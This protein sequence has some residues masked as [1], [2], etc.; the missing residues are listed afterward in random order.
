MPPSKAFCLRGQASDTF[1][2][3]LCGGVRSTKSAGRVGDVRGARS[4]KF[5][6]CLPLDKCLEGRLELG[7]VENG[8]LGTD[9]GG[10][11]T[12]IFGLFKNGKK[13]EDPVHNDG[14]DDDGARP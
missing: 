3:Y 1:T 14:R 12:S 9:R 2:E 6:L 4:Q 10:F 13:L 8:C 7:A 5:V 11:R